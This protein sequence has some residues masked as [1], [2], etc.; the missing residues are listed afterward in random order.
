L[1]EG[2]MDGLGVSVVIPTH[3]RAGL[4]GRA[5]ASALAAVSD[6]DEVIVVDDGST[7]PTEQ[8]LAP[9]RGR[10]RYARVRHGGAGA[11]R[12]HGVGLARCPLVA[13]LDSDDAWMPDKLALQRALMRARP[14]VL[15]CFSDFAVRTPDG[16]EHRRYLV[17]WHDDRRPWDEILG[18]GVAFSSLAALPAGRA[19]F[20]VHAGDLYPGLLER[21]YVMTI[22]L[23]VRRAAAGAALHYPEDVPYAEDWECFARLARAGTAAYLDCE[24]AWQHG[25]TGARITDTDRYT[26]ATHRLAVVERVWGRDER[27]LAAHAARYRS[28]V[29]GL[30]LVRAQGLIVRGRMAE[31]RAALDR[32]GGGPLGYRVLTRL[33]GPLARGLLALRRR[34]AGTA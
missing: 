33:P 8:A 34:L 27:F 29:A 11:A 16:A 22:T 17:N 3:N 5:V 14:D 32:A 12:N 19:D 4:V 23:V 13:F 2:E 20:R 6:G 25:H 1:E 15:F 21:L 24:T 31:A 26:R 10:I 7:D 18:P 28:A 30:H 9:Y